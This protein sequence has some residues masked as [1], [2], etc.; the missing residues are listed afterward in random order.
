MIPENDTITILF[1]CENSN[2]DF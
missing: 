1:Q 2:Q